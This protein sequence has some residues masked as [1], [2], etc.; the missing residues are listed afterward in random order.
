MSQIIKNQTS[1][2]PTPPDVPTSFVT[3][4][5]IAVPA[6]NILNVFGAG[7]TSTSGAGN[8]I[9]IT[10]TA[11]TPFNPNQLVT[12]FDDFITSV[13]DTGGTKLGWG[14]IVA[15][16]GNNLYGQVAGTAT[17]PGIIA[18]QAPTT[19]VA[20]ILLADD[21]NTG[22]RTAPFLLGGG[23]FSMNWVFDLGTLSDVTDRYIAYIGLTDMDINDTPVVQP[24]N[25][26]FFKYSDNLNAGNWQIICGKAGVYTTVNTAVPASI[27]FHNYGISINAAATSATFSIDGVAVG[28]VIITNIPNTVPMG[29]SIII[30]GVSGT[31]PIHFIDLFYYTQTLTTAR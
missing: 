31:L 24:Q 27:G 29:P 16:I 8:T 14:P 7:T 23:T 10:S 4:S 25:G 26:C 1:S 15:T 11:S 22:V 30:Q 17:N 6:L 18:N 21:N 12:D 13:I 5:G 20:G 28:S 19:D 3:D 9:T 2:G